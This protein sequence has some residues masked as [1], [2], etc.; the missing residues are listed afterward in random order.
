MDG[1]TALMV[2][3]VQ[4]AFAHRDA[5]GA[6]R[7]TPE[8][9]Q[10]ISRLLA[11][12]RDG[13]APVIHVHHRSH[14]KGSA[15]RAGLPGVE[16]QPFAQPVGEESVYV[17]HVNSAFI[18]TTLESD[19][20]A[21]GIARLILCGAIANHCVETTARMAGNLGF[22]VLYVRDAVWAYGATSPDG[23]VFAP[24]DV[25]AMTLANLSDEFA[26][27]APTDAVLADL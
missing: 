5:Q 14:Q 13:R 15:F 20:R 26:R 23:R 17:K 21:A 19:L 27:V 11:S 18:R 9:E 12:F 2:I 7:T 22:D 8:A 4:M 16:V 10:N 24:D 6:A 25:L 3:D 1:S